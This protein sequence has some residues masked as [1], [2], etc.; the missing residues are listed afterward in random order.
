[1]K[2]VQALSEEEVEIEANV[3]AI[4]QKKLKDRKAKVEIMKAWEN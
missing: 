2:R 3:K 1:M 4:E